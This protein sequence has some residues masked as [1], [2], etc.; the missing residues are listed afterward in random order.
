MCLY[1]KFDF[2]GTRII[3]DV[4]YQQDREEKPVGKQIG[5][6][7]SVDVFSSDSPSFS[8]QSKYRPIGIFPCKV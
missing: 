7:C 5:P 1:S 3:K 6:E 8:R 4:L 2:H